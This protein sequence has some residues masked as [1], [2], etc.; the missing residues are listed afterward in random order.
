MELYPLPAYVSAKL[1]TAVDNIAAC[2]REPNLPDGFFH[3]IL[4]A[5]IEYSVPFFLFPKLRDPDLEMMQRA[6]AHKQVLGMILLAV[7]DDALEAVYVGLSAYLRA[8][9]AA[10]N[11]VQWLSNILLYSG[12]GSVI[13]TASPMLLERLRELDRRV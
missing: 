3:D 11:E 13:G 2:L 4:D 8:R 9:P 12:Q 5:A 6:F 10:R 1:V 7:D